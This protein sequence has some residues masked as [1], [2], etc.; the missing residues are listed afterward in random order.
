MTAD[1]EI[2]TEVSDGVGQ[3]T[4]NRPRRI[5]ALN[6]SMIDALAETF[7]RW[8]TDDQITGI[9][10][11]G[12]GDRG[13][14]AGADIVT[15]RRQILD[16]QSDALIT[17]L[18]HEYDLDALIATYPKPVTA[19]LGGVAMGGGLGIGL[20]TAERIG[21]SSTRWAMPETAIG[22]WPDVGVS[23]ELARAP[24]QIGR[25][26][27]MTGESLDA[28]SACWA[29]LLD[30][31]TGIREDDVATSWASN[32]AVW[33][34]ECFSA[35]TPVEVLDR[36]RSTDNLEAHKVLTII[37]SRCPLSVCVAFE[38]I[39]RAGAMESVTEVLDMDRALGRAWNAD[40]DEFVEG[41]R[42]K[43][44]DKDVP[45]WRHRHVSEVAQSEVDERFNA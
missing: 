34:E 21:D 15:L 5:N 40:P 25:Y 43:M 11:R 9:Q 20:H 10:L 8:E 1:L 13:F 35:S 28:A 27:A 6:L 19:Y 38:L 36:L 39:N 33:I 45:R 44:V 17:F 30:H 23:F 2:L 37:E 29:G 22:L 3:I 42:S 4:L 41:V 32:N 12:A 14:C 16:G 31:A 24:R 7:T 26:L 18:N